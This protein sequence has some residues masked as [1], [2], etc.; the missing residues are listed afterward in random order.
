VLDLREHDEGWV[1]SKL[2]D[3]WLGFSDTQLEALMKGAGFTHT[4]VRVGAR[5][6][7]DPFTVLIASGERQTL[8][9]A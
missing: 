3:R 5:R 8:E 6:E 7:N 4:V 9:K 2:G 1:R